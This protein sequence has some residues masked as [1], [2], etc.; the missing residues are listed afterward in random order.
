MSAK[1]KKPVSTIQAILRATGLALMAAGIVLAWFPHKI[2]DYL[3]DMSPEQT[4][5][6]GGILI[7]FGLIDLLVLPRLFKKHEEK[8]D[9]D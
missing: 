3:G 1:D 6:L 2:E 9:N 7:V 5:N 4:S 8:K